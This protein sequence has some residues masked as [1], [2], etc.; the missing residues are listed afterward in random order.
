MHICTCTSA[1]SE[2]IY[3]IGALQ[4][5]PLLFL[6]TFLAFYVYCAFIKMIYPCNFILHV[7]NGIN[8]H[9]YKTIE[10]HNLS[11]PIHIH[12]QAQIHT[13]TLYKIYIMCMCVR[14]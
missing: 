2:I 8:I 10:L 1:C 7:Y 12:M 6:I 14:I 3:V 9:A 5:L 13:P 11:A 4:L